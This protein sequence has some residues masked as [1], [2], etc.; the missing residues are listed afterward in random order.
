MTW[1]ELSLHAK[2]EAVDWIYTLLV[3]PDD[4]S[5]LHLTKYTAPDPPP[6]LEPD[7]NSE[8]WAF[9]LYLYLPNDGRMWER[10]EKIKQLLSSLSR[11]GLTTDFEAAIVEEKPAFKADVASLMHRIGHRFVVLS[12]DTPVQSNANEITIKLGTTRSFGS[13]LHPATILSLQLL[14]R[15]VVPGMQ[16]L[17]LGSGSGILSVAIA[18]LG[19][20]VLAVDNDS[21]AVQATQDAVRQNH[22]EPQVTVMQG[23][24]GKGTEL[25]HWMGGNL[26]EPVSSIDP[27]AR[28]DLIVAN[29]LARVHTTLAPDFYR[30]LRQTDAH[31]GL[32]IASGFT[33]EYAE[34]VTSAMKEV[35]FEAID[36]NH[37]GR[38]GSDRFYA[39]GG[40]ERMKDEG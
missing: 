3:E 10:L 13:G 7:Q 16:V 19:A 1:M 38:M 14:E 6:R 29:I 39:T 5:D 32:L 4:A 9:T 21:V 36:Q 28:F 11:T 17:D 30:S 22:V 2:H 20:Q 40:K 34:S 15:Y 18:K 35:G 27:T 24:L 23:S 26:P 37:L 12:P 33:T 31:S 25:G 8:D